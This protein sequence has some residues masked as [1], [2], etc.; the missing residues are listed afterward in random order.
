MVGGVPLSSGYAAESGVIV[1]GIDPGKR[2]CGVA[3]GGES[4]LYRAR[5]LAPPFPAQF[6]GPD[7]DKVYLELMRYRTGD[8]RSV[9]NDL[10]DVATQGAL[11][12][13][14]LGGGVVLVEPRT[15][16][17]TI[18]G[19]AMV[20]RIRGRLTPQE[21]ACVELPRAVKTLGHNVWDAVGIYLWATGRLNP[22]RG[23]T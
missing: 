13:G 18:D 19:D 1:Y 11:L 21:I 7:A 15:W 9:P 6:G 17:G 2:G 8:R 20:E 4:V 10:L 5:Y 12:A 16:K 23:G 22:K 14:S 3:W